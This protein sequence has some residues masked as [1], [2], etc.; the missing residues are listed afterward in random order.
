[1]AIKRVRTLE[2]A[3]RGTGKRYRWKRKKLY[4]DTNYV[5]RWRGI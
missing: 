5:F 2:K 1:M 4:V 3:T